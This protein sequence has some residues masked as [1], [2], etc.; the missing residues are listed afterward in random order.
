MLRDNADMMVPI[1]RLTRSVIHNSLTFSHCLFPKKI[2]IDRVDPQW[3]KIKRFK[4]KRIQNSLILALLNNCP[5]KVLNTY[6]LVLN[7]APDR[8]QNVK[9]RKYF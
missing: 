9:Y 6:D 5:T 2:V 7:E 4:G 1:G 3:I 8:I